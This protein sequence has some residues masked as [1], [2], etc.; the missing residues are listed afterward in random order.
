MKKRNMAASAL[1]AAMLLT[2]CGRVPDAAVT[3]TEIVVPE[4]S[5]K[6]MLVNSLEY[7]LE[8]EP[9]E[10][11]GKE[12]EAAQEKEQQTEAD[13]PVIES[14]GSQEE[15]ATVICYGKD[16]DSGLTEEVITA[17]HITPDVLL[18]ALA[19]HNIVPLLDTKARSM[20]EREE[21]G[22]KL[23]YLDLSGSFR[24]Y[25]M[26]M[27]MEA[28]CIIMSSIVNTFTINY[29]ADAVYITVEGETLVTSNAA[30]TEA[31]AGYTPGEMMTYLTALEDGGYEED[32]DSEKQ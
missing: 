18:N 31:V 10:E 32:A 15:K 20:E 1:L 16:V 24:E 2:A 7:L 17:E 8:E 6:D 5:S 4:L 13:K 14:E 29:H 21:D 27:S 25:L 12:E 23:I 3:T 9:E 22:R 28:E 19:R 26:T 30:Y 11:T